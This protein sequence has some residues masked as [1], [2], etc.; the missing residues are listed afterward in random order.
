MDILDIVKN[1]VNRNE[2]R[3]INDNWKEIID[4]V[5]SGNSVEN[6]AKEYNID[7][8]LLKTKLSHFNN[9][10]SNNQEK[11]NKVD[12]K[13]SSDEKRLS[14]K[15]I[16]EASTKLYRGMTYEKIAN[17]YY[18]SESSLI[19]EFETYNFKRRWII[20][21]PLIVQP[22]LNEIIKELN[23]NNK[24]LS[25]ISTQYK[26]DIKT[27]KSMLK[28]TRYLE[29]SRIDSE[30]FTV[31]NKELILVTN[32]EDG[33]LKYINYKGKVLI[34][35]IQ[36]NL[37]LGINTGYYRKDS[38]IKDVHFVKVEKD[39]LT[40]IISYIPYLDY[41]NI[42]SFYTKSGIE[43]FAKL[44]KKE[45]FL[46][47]DKYKNFFITKPNN[48]KKNEIVVESEIKNQVNNEIVKTSGHSIEVSNNDKASEITSN[49]D[50]KN[51]SDFFNEWHP[52]GEKGIIE[53]L[54]TEL[55]N[56]LTFYDLSLRYSKN[57]NYRAGFSSKLQRKLVAEGYILNMKTDL[58][59][60]KYEENMTQSSNNDS[61]IDPSHIIRNTPLNHTSINE[62]D[63]EVNKDNLTI[64][65]LV[66]YLN[67]TD[68]IS[69]AEKMFGISALDIRLMLKS[70]GYSY[71]SI[72][73]RWSTKN[74]IE[75]LKD[76]ANDLKQGITSFEQLEGEGLNA[77][78]LRRNLEELNLEYVPSFKSDENEIQ[79]EIYEKESNNI[80]N[81]TFNKPINNLT[82]DEINILRDIISNWK[83]NQQQ[84]ESDK[85]KV[86]S[87]F[88]V[89]KSLIQEIEMYS[90]TM[91]MSKSN[92][93]EK[94]LEEFFNRTKIN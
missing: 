18:L 92:V 55:N 50:L 23:T 28:E 19:D 35:S 90:E 21:D 12:I 30:S 6:V 83:E 58:W 33:K 84:L 16:Q 93:I 34:T 4:L 40:E 51:Y 53:D 70:N 2:D 63:S 46:L 73:K 27:L 41:L 57:K 94:A 69:Q 88:F 91:D 38:F 49:K 67:I 45:S 8:D 29:T 14:F 42:V 36:L 48:E 72:L 74:R 61:I 71:H 65:E 60:R 26:V 20:A 75:L 79:E 9:F 24:E 66:V 78:N 13:Y 56:G 3:Q 76:V 5:K 62:I 81:A 54:V 87:V 47:S 1:V 44:S 85:D 82:S 7:S 10:T 37:L 17:E 68:S 52:K 39:I 22:K 25:D 64:E 59:E 77:E 31:I 15:Q 86:K 11:V 80:D 32:V 89:K 43:L